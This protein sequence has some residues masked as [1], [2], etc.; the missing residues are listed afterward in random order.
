MPAASKAGWKVFS[1]SYD[2]PNSNAANA[3]DGDPGTIW[4]TYGP[5]GEHHLPQEIAVDLRHEQTVKG[6]TYLPRQDGCF[7]GMVD[8]YAFLL[9][10]DGKTWKQVAEGE[11]GNLRANPIEQKVSFAPTRARYFKFVA[12]HALELNHAVVAELGIVG[13]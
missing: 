7:H 11:F 1:V 13:P 2:N 9:S 6:F 5:D 10:T 12:K 3:I 4:H 8:Q